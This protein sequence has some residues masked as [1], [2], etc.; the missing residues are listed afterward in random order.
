LQSAV[1]W[2]P[3]DARTRYELAA[4]LKATGDAAG[5]ARELARARTLDPRL[6]AVLP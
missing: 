6:P 1:T 4:A 5:A 3:A 2:A